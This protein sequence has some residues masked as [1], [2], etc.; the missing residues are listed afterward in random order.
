[1]DKEN[2][3]QNVIELKII[4]TRVCSEI[5]G[6]GGEVDGISFAKGALLVPCGGGTVLEVC[7]SLPIKIYYGI[8]SF[9]LSSEPTALITFGYLENEFSFV[10]TLVF[11]L[12]DVFGE[13]LQKD[14]LFT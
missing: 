2:G 11:C 14:V 5:R 3:Q 10:G 13:M 1:M 12:L 7:L 9:G 8:W 6:E 4:T